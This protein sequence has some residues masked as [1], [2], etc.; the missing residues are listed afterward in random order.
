MRIKSED[1]YGD[2]QQNY[3]KKLAHR[4]QTCRP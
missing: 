2:G 1:L 3:A 4:N